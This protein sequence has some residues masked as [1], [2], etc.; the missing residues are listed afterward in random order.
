MSLLMRT[1]VQQ[2]SHKNE[3]L[4]YSITRVHRLLMSIPKTYISSFTTFSLL[5]KCLRTTSGPVP[6]LQ[7]LLQ[8]QEVASNL[9]LTCHQSVSLSFFTTAQASAYKIYTCI[10]D[11]K[12]CSIFNCLKLRLL[13]LVRFGT[14]VIFRE[15]QFWSYKVGKNAK[16]V[17]HQ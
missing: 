15:Q 9:S 4:V 13:P 8:L 5:P 2:E 1:A 6:L 10:I 16:E 7:L 12:Q 3:C 14:A 11:I 17:C